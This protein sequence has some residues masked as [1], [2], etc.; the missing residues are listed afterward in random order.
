MHTGPNRLVGHLVNSLRRHDPDQV[1]R[2]FLSF[3]FLANQRTPVN[4]L[5]YYIRAIGP[6][7]KIRLAQG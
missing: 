7:V 5:K 2:V 4:K 3:G 6:R 1:L